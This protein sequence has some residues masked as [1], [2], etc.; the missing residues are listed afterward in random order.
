VIILKINSE[1]DNIK[2]KIPI[3]LVVIIL[4]TLSIAQPIFE[5][6]NSIFVHED[7]PFIGLTYSFN[8]YVNSLYNNFFIYNNLDYSGVIQRGMISP[9]NYLYS[10]LVLPLAITNG[11]LAN[12]LENIVFLLIGSLGM[13]IFL[14]KLFEKSGY[15]IRITSSLIGTLIFFPFI[16]GESSF[17]PF[18]FLFILLILRNFNNKTYKLKNNSLVLFGLIISASFLFTFGGYNYLIPDFILFVLLI[19]VIPIFTQDK[20]LNLFFILLLAFVIALLINLIIFYGAYLLSISKS[21]NISYYSFMGSLPEPFAT[22]NILYALQILPFSNNPVIFTLK[23]LL[24]ALSV[25]GVLIYLNK[26]KHSPNSTIIIS[27]LI[28]FILITFFYNTIYK[29][30]GG[31]FKFLILNFKSLYA[32]RSG[33]GSFSYIMG[34]VLS[35]FSSATIIFYRDYLKNRELIFT[36]GILIFILISIGLFYYNDITPYTNINYFYVKI[37]N[38]VYL[39]S[40]YINN[41]SG[42]FNVGILPSAAGFQYLDTWYTGTNIYSYLINKPVYTGGYIAQSEIFYPVTKYLYDDVSSEIDN[43]K[44]NDSYISQIFGIL[45][46]KYILVQGNALESS[47]YDQNYYDP[48]NLNEVYINLNNTYNIKFVKRYSNT[49]IYENL[50]YVPLIYTTNIYNIGNSSDGGLIKSITNQSFDIKTDSV[51]ITHIP[52]FYNDSDTINASSIPNFKEPEIKFNYNNPTQIT[53]KV[54]NATTPFYLVF[55]ETY[56]SPW[57]AYIN[58]KPIPSKYHIAVNGFANAWY[59]NKTGNYTITLY[60]TLQ[61]DADVA[62][63]VSFAALFATIGIGIYGWKESKKSKAKSNKRI[64]V[65]DL[66]F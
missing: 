33:D 4:I 20:R 9:L 43:N 47:P 2:Q 55:R 40:N 35:V 36:W 38:H 65:K 54:R 60:Y 62:W 48:F 32:I 23:L 8:Q 27:L 34:F 64:M 10:L 31:I 44:L 13:F 46:I 5:F 24:F 7:T 56:G 37:P 28:I 57:H 39:V 61:T 52:D 41:K 58:G 29:P 66:G 16:G 53:V 22:S 21:A 17:L 26:I 25:S 18:C 50:D 19:I 51:Y 3:Y 11:I 49:S 12:I 15:Y 14:Y 30:F 59:I 6:K 63:I 1:F 42:Y 45:G